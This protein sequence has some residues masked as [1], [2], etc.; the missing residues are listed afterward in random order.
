MNNS[1]RV[2]TGSDKFLL[3]DSTKPLTELM[4]TYYQY[5]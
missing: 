4:Q 2:H 1:I 3:P 5:E